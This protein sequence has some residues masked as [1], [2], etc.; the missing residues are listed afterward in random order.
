[1][2][3]PDH[4][5]VEP[6]KVVKS[7]DDVKK[8]EAS[9]AYE[10]YIGF[11]QAVGDSVVG[12]TI[13][14]TDLR[15]SPATER[16]LAMLTKLSSWIDEIPAVEQQQRFGNMAYRTWHEKLVK[17]A[18]SLAKEVLAD[19]CPAASVE[20][21]AYLSDS[22]GNATRID[23]GTGHEMAFVVYLCSLFMVG[24]WGDE[25][26]PA[27]GL[28]VF[29]R[30]LDVCRKL[31]NIY[32]MEPAGS[33]GVWNL[34]DYQ[35]VPFIWGAA[36][37]RKGAQVRPKSIPD[38]DIAN[39]LAD[40]YHFFACIKHISEVKRGPFAEHSNQLW[41]VSGVQTWDKVNQGLV[42]MYR[43]EVLSKFPVMQ[44]FFF[45]SLFT[46]DKAEQPLLPV[47][48]AASGMRERAMVMKPLLQ[49]SIPRPDKVA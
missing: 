31:Q 9:K 34:D 44:H 14:S 25:D 48:T 21:A 10:Q 28:K 45:G 30:Y 5:F 46:L 12:K 47:A 26:R 22:F 39:M 4:K 43:A 17:E 7:V 23:Y 38:Y 49:S 13:R 1:M 33:Q 19:V 24:V 8:W 35:F 42:K 15:V 27:V 16:V 37:M 11:I 18:D 36:Q 40:D 2:I 3:G 41:N 29:G 32:R 6:V 20:L